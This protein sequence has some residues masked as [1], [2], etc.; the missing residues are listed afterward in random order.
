MSDTNRE[1]PDGEIEGS[2]DGNGGWLGWLGASPE[3]CLVALK[4]KAAQGDALPEELE[5]LRAVIAQFGFAPIE[6]AVHRVIGLEAA[7]AEISGLMGTRPAT[8]LVRIQEIVRTCVQFSGDFGM[9]DEDLPTFLA[10]KLEA[11]LP[12][13]EDIVV[14]PPPGVSPMGRVLPSVAEILD[15]AGRRAAEEEGPDRVH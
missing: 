13:K 10:A 3:W 14:D 5:E 11:E 4:W 7:F 1:F 6:Q 12:K 8:S 9:R 15:K 2:L